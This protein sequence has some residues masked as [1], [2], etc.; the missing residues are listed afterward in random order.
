MLISKL[1]LRVEVVE[2]ANTVRDF[3]EREF[4]DTLVWDQQEY[5]PPEL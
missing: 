3:C 2:F 4:K 5:L 1:G